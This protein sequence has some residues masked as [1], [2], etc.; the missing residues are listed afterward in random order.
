MN[1]EIIIDKWRDR[2]RASLDNP[3]LSLDG[4]PKT[5]D[6]DDEIDPP[7]PIAPGA[8]E[9]PCRDCPEGMEW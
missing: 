5:V 1:H 4:E 7:R 8:I 3:K 6:T 2:A 9:E